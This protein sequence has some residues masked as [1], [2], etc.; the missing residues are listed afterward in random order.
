VTLAVIDNYDS[1]T[2]NLV[3][4]LAELGAQPAVYRND[5]VG[6]D[7]L[8]QHSGLVISPGPGD[9]AQ[10]GVSTEAVRQLSGE[11]PILGVCLGH[12]CLA[13]AFGAE[14]VRGRPVHGKTSAVH[15]DGEA[16]F[17][18]LPDPFQATRYH[19]LVVDRTTLPPELV[20]SAWTDDGVVMG[21]RHREHPTY[22]V[23]FH[24]ESI[25]TPEGKRILAGF[26]DRCKS[27]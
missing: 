6:P 8:R 13:E 19:S 11:I 20:V 17:R 14:V 16:P 7:R 26:L 1:F 9:P 4:Y 12:Q 21:L 25:L 5:E 15:H 27:S 3:Q 23:Q 2:Y 22:G 10:A 18:G 24:P